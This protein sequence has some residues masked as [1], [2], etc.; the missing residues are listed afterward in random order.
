VLVHSM[1]DDAL[2][3]NVQW[4]L[5]VVPR[6]V[7][8]VARRTWSDR[9]HYGAAMHL[10]DFDRCVPLSR[11]QARRD[12]PSV[13]DCESSKFA[14]DDAQIADNS[15]WRNVGCLVQPRSWQACSQSTRSRIHRQGYRDGS[16]LCGLFELSRYVSGCQRETS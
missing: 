8:H 5:S 10:Q 7:E 6:V 12:Q 2:G 4:L 9:C 13:V 15:R 1:T 11:V 14:R 3:S 16:I